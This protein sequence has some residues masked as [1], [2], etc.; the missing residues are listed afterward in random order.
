M[1]AAIPAIRADQFWQNMCSG[2]E[3]FSVNPLGWEFTGLKSRQQLQ[4]LKETALVYDK[5][6]IQNT[7][8]DYSFLHVE[9][10]H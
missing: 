6:P 5:A 8:G 3:G 1:D 2:H 7:A 9:W 4:S 10:L